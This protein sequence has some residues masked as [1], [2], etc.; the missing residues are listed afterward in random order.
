MKYGLQI[1]HV[2]FL[3]ANGSLTG[4]IPSFAQHSS[5]LVRMYKLI[6]LTRVFDQK[7]I[8]MFL[9]GK[10]GTYPSSLGEE[11][12]D[13]GL[14]CALE[15]TPGNFFAPYYRNHG[16]F[17]A[18]NGIEAFLQNLLFWG[19]DER[20]NSLASPESCLP[21]VIPIGTQYGMAV[22]VAKGRRLQ[23]KEGAVVVVGGD[24]STSK[25]DFSTALNEAAT[26][27]LPVVFVI[28]NNRWAISMPVAEQTRTH[29]LALRGSGFAMH[30]KTVDGNDVIAVRHAASVA[31]AQARQ[32]GGP[33]L[34][35]AQT[36]RLADHTTV[37]IGTK[38]PYRKQEEVDRA[39]QSEPLLRMRKLLTERGYWSEEK[40]MLFTEEAKKQMEEIETAYLA[41][42]Q[43][44]PG[45][46]V[47]YLFERVPDVASYREQLARLTGK[48]V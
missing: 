41:Y 18:R 19:G 23:K 37:E 42:P 21:F 27:K 16:T 15:E 24:G 30:A 1:D 36:Y 44:K 45:D 6:V 47:E 40:E 48:E 33:T 5:E 39:W 38:Q 14:G 13:V 32:G 22:G 34:I 46:M 35:E 11:A 29:P 7:A 43:Q 17:L 2:V 25:G 12:I 31:I 9:S 20:G 4:E 10:I 8:S 26:K 3:D 28:K